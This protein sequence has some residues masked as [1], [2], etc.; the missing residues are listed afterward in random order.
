MMMRTMPLYYNAA[1]ATDDKIERMKLVIAQS[2][3]Y[4]YPDKTF[5]KPIE[6]GLGE[7]LQAFG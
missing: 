2:I 4:F 7:T 3:N 5:E 1:A 6:P